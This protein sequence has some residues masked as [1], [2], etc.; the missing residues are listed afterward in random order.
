MLDMFAENKVLIVP[1]KDIRSWLNNG[2]ELDDIITSSWMSTVTAKVI[3]SI[4][5]LI[6]IRNFKT[7][8]SPT[9]TTA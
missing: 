2:E 1:D 9:T 8:S 4:P 6:S 5:P 3:L 7:S